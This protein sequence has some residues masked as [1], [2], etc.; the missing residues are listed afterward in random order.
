MDK[1]KEHL[2]PLIISIGKESEGKAKF[3]NRIARK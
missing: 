1:P 2:N 3:L